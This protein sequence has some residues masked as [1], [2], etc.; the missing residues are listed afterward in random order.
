[1]TTLLTYRGTVYPWHCDQVG[2][3]NVMWYVGKFDEATWQ[4]F[5][6]IGLTPSY[7]HANQRGMAA[8]DQHISYER[9][10]RSGAVVSVTSSVREVHTKRIVFVHE[11]RNDESGEVAAR[12]TLTAVHM[13]TIARKSC[14][15]PAAVVD[16]A[17]ALAGEA[18]AATGK[19]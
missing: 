12:T 10:L 7:M 14:A 1:M 18:P 13:D 19:V 17:R 4:L 3:M 8:V 6:A 11:M 15:F 9:E 2:H 16:A 5:N